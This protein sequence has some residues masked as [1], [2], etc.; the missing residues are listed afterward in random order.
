V[1]T[2]IASCPLA[3]KAVHFTVEFLLGL[4]DVA[5]CPLFPAGM[6]SYTW[7]GRQN[8]DPQAEKG[9]LVVE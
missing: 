6:S 1:K 2:D 3:L 4:S 8:H 5:I 9:I 7:R